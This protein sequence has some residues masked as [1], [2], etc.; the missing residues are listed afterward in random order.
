MTTPLRS[1]TC[2][3]QASRSVVGCRVTRSALTGLELAL[4]ARLVSTPSAS[5]PQ[6]P[7][8]AKWVLTRTSPP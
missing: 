7:G 3:L 4:L 6:S 5:T 2:R 8:K 1:T